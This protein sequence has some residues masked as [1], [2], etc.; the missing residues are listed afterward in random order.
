PAVF[1]NIGNS[2]PD[3][4]LR[5]S[6]IHRPAVQKDLASTFG[7][8]AEHSFHQLCSSCTY[9]PC[10]SYNFS[11]TGSK[12]CI[13][14]QFRM[15]KISGFQRNFSDIMFIFGIEAGQFTSYHQTDQMVSVRF[16]CT[17]ISH[18]FSVTKYHNPVGDLE[19]FLQTMGYINDSDIL[20]PEKADNTKKNLHFSL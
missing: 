15:R 1:G 17:D 14:E 10:K 20:F 5:T 6:D 13:T 2:M 16:F 8:G 9:Q 7:I 3:C 11:I 19:Q 12:T 4:V 18:H